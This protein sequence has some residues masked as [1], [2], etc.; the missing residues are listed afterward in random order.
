V[1]VGQFFFFFW[2]KLKGSVEM[3]LFALQNPSLKRQKCMIGVRVM[4]QSFCLA[5]MQYGGNWGI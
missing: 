1:F 5:L 3:L 4:P 2:A